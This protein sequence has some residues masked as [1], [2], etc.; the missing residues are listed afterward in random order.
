MHTHAASVYTDGVAERYF[1]L[2]MQAVSCVVLELCVMFAV[3]L[4]YLTLNL[5]T[6]KANKHTNNNAAE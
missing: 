1:A 6:L 5:V 3:L 4:L 2:L